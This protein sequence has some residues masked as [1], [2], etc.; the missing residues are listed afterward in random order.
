[1][2]GAHF[3]QQVIGIGREIGLNFL[4]LS[5]L[6]SNGNNNIIRTLEGYSVCEA[7]T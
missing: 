3:L 2:S 5:F 4:D 6:T 1:M 7:S